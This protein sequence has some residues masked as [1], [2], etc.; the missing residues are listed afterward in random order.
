MFEALFTWTPQKLLQK[1]GSGARGRGLCWR[2]TPAKPS[3]LNRVWYSQS[4]WKHFGK[5][6]V[7]LEERDKQLNLS[8]QGQDKRSHQLKR[9]GARGGSKEARWTDREEAFGREVQE[10]QNWWFTSNWIIAADTHKYLFWQALFWL[11]YMHNF[12]Y[13]LQQ[14]WFTRRKLKFWEFN[15]LPKVTQPVIRMVNIDPKQVGSDLNS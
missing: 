11:L 8:I 3:I 9:Q 12:I 6:V 13:S 15:N 7:K 2:R 4:E 5:H 10:C 14:F 1:G